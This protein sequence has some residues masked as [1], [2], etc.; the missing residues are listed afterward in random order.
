MQ[1]NTE[2]FTQGAG[3]ALID[4][5]LALVADHTRPL[6]ASMFENADQA[7]LEFADKAESNWV[8]TRF[9][10][11]M[12]EVRKK[13]DRMET[14]FFR[15]LD[16]NF[17]AFGTARAGAGIA[18]GADEARLTLVS[19][20]DT[21]ETV[22]VQNMVSRAAVRS[23]PELYALR[24]RLALLNDGRKLEEHEVPGGPTGMADAFRTATADLELDYKTRLIVYMLFDK[25]VMSRLGDLYR[26]YNQHL[27]DAGLLPNLR[28]EIR[29]QPVSTRQGTRK[30][31]P[32]GAEG[33]VNA[34]V[35]ISAETADAAARHDLAD[36]AGTGA[37]LPVG[38]ELF[39]S[40][41]RLLSHR[42]AS[43]PGSTAGGRPPG[44]DVGG[45]AI[46]VEPVPQAE[47]V[48][49]LHELQQHRHDGEYPGGRDVELIAEIRHDKGVVESMVSVLAAEREQ[50]FAGVDRRRVPA[51]DTQ[52]IDLVG[53]IF[54][55]VLNDD[56]LPNVV[57]ALLS[58]LHTPFLKVA[59]I[60]RTFFTDIRHPARQLLDVLAQAGGRWVFEDDL[61]RGIFPWMRAAVEQV[62]DE[63][64]SNVDI[65]HAILEVF[66]S[67]LQEL[68]HKAAIIEERT[69]QAAAGKEKLELARRYAVTEIARLARGHRVPAAISMQLNEVWQNKLMFVHLREREA[70]QSE[71]WKLAVQTIQDILWS[72]EPCRT[73]KARV[74]L[75]EKLPEL[76]S[77]I[78]QSLETLAAYGNSDVVQQFSV[79]EQCQDAVVQASDADAVAHMQPPAPAAAVRE[80]AS[81]DGHPST[82]DLGDAREGGEGN[83]MPRR[84]AQLEAVLYQLNN[85][86]FGTWFSIEVQ[87]G[88]PPLRL[89][90]AWFSQLSGQYMF[91]DSMGVRVALKGREELAGLL[92]EGRARIHS[93]EQR[94]LVIRA[95]ESIRRIL[96][97][98]QKAEA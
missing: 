53:M 73:Q 41:L 13:R 84:S 92:T 96:G 89:K 90:L 87:K 18:T 71:I 11:A 63:F 27:I 55:Y 20:E 22:A 82:G 16:D 85:V 94:P 91:V 59:V 69:K 9:I 80:P 57:K 75:R 17:A 26:E 86:A 46:S 65:F 40:I 5:C 79:I 72:V 32:A 61:Q 36:A 34:G 8:R 62:L 74:E 56:E 68:E 4:E 38:E 30:S 76:R 14:S 29:K 77:R 1:A 39:N 28:Y 81:S 58:R 23:L 93:E 98:D 19:K 83:A 3:G 24:Q 10:D 54:E 35:P 31:A 45:G 97:G 78:R 44:A 95:L 33:S 70:G 60:D 7:L 6:V 37:D 21:E 64:D 43:G 50:L 12:T 47:L 66:R 88:E 51:A 52:V 49:A 25:F 48:S 67:R 42:H 2:S 15:A